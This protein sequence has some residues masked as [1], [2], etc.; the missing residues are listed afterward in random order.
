MLYIAFVYLAVHLVVLSAVLSAVLRAVFCHSVDRSFLSLDSFSFALFIFV[1]CSRMLHLRL[2]VR[3]S[4]RGSARGT[5]HRIQFIPGSHCGIAPTPLSD[6]RR[7]TVGC[8]LYDSGSHICSLSC[9]RCDFSPFGMHS[10]LVRMIDE[11]VNHFNTGE[12]EHDG[13]HPAIGLV[14]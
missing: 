14:P 8:L 11:V 4:R 1:S 5:V 2:F 3:Q 10:S 13:Y 12:M 7:G 6:S 9:L